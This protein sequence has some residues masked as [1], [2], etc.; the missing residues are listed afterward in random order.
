MRAL[1]VGDFVVPRVGI[2]A[3]TFVLLPGVG[4]WDRLRRDRFRGSQSQW[5]ASRKRT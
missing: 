3:G 2:A 5:V 4:G 1:S